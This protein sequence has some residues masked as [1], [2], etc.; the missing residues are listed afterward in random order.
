MS[1]IFILVPLSIVFAT[2][3]LVAFI[4]AVRSGQFDDT[5][6]P[7]MRLLADEAGQSKEAR[8]D[9]GHSPA[10]RAA[11]GLRASSPTD[12]SADALVHSASPSQM[13][14]IDTNASENSSMN[15]DLKSI[16]P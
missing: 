8:R 11:D 13:A 7:S 14:P 6:T 12:R 3:F 1:A 2:G 4:W 5:S 9:V 16:E 10:P 15:Q